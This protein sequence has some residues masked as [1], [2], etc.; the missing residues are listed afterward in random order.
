MHCTPAMTVQLK[1]E[2]DLELTLI[3]TLPQFSLKATTKTNQNNLLGILLKLWK[4]LAIILLRMAEPWLS[5]LKRQSGPF[6]F[7]MNDCT[8]IVTESGS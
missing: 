6:T 4:Y 2:L 5:C 3:F 1:L 8:E 7:Q